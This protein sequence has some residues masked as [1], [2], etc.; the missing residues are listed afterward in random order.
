MKSTV[1][2]ATFEREKGEPEGL[3]LNF[4]AKSGSGP[5]LA[6]RRQPFTVAKTLLRLGYMAQTLPIDFQA[7]NPLLATQSYITLLAYCPLNR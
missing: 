1:L 5:I 4:V 7:A 6:L 2:R 3:R